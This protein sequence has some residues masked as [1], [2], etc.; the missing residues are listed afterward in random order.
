[1]TEATGRKEKLA[2]SIHSRLFVTPRV[3]EKGSPRTSDASPPVNY[4]LS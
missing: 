2:K 1:M 3:K 4:G